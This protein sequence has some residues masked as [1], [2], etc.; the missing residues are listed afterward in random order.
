MN[1]PTPTILLVEDDANDVLLLQRA[2]RKS[3]LKS[4][5][6]VASDGE[7]ATSY[8]C[9]EGDFADRATYPLPSLVVLDLKLPRKSGLEVLEW[10]RQ[11]KRPLNLL[12]VVILTSSRQA[13]DI[14]KAY[15]LGANFY[16]VKP[17][18]F[19]RLLDI[20]KSLDTYW[21]FLNETPHLP[22]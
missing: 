17:G 22:K 3:N 19:D 8:L 13:R 7:L 1:T 11:Q 4:H 20:V 5:M 10:I 14:D 6:Q 12:P 2:L 18:E 9:G 16:H 21:F 15:E